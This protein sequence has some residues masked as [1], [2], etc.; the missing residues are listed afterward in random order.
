MLRIITAPRQIWRFAAAW[1][2]AGSRGPSD[3]AGPHPA[4]MGAC[5]A[6]HPYPQR[7]APLS[8]CRPPFCA[9]RVPSC[10]GAPS[11]ARVR[12][13]AGRPQPLRGSGPPP[14]G[15]GPFRPLPS[16]G[17]GRCPRLFRSALV[18]R[19]RGS[20]GSLW[21]RLPLA[22]AFL[23]CGL[24]VRSALLRAALGR[25]Q[26]VASPGPPLAVR[27][28]FGPPAAFASLGP[29]GFGPGLLR[30]GGLS[31]PAAGSLCLRPPGCGLR[32]R[33]PAGVPPAG[34]ALGPRCL[35]FGGRLWLGFAPAGAALFP[36]PGA[37]LLR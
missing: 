11:P 15:R 7:C 20:A 2:C 29:G 5:F 9:L 22:P 3:G 12:S 21:P 14:S 18:C 32:P 36:H 10:A 28:G 19:C 35:G 16:P 31:R 33:P 25:V 27:S 17:P 30:P 24:P 34:V 23:C 6:A 37:L 13:G 1:L 26:R 4:H 8:A